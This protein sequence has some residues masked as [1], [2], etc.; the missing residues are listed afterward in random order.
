[1]GETARESYERMIKLVSEAEAAAPGV[2]PVTGEAREDW[3][4][5]A[6]LR[7]AV[8]H[9]QGTPVLAKLDASPEAVG[10]S[11]SPHIGTV[12]TQGPLTP[13]H[14]IRT[15]R[16]PALIGDD[17]A[18]SVNAYAEDYAA[19]FQKHATEGQTQLPPAPN[20]AVWPGRGLV[21]FGTTVKD[22]GI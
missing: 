17:I 19:Y 11:N 4:G 12:A 2:P 22:A 13:D 6:E 1:W 14:S 21:A 18:T 5:L 10:F 7:R 20:W 9:A 8:S 16:I 15:K 3:L